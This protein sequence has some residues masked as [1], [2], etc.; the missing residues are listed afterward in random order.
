MIT[1]DHGNCEVMI[2]DDGSINTQHT[3][4]VVPLV[5]IGMDSIKLKHGRLSDLA[6]TMLD[7]MGLEKPKEM[8]GNSLIERDSI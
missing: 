6:P 1:A 5:I 3:T 2:N 7:I 8:K 4:N